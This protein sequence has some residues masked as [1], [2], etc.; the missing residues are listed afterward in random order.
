MLLI[1]ERDQFL[2]LFK[3]GEIKI[4]LSRFIDGFDVENNKSAITAET[5][6]SRM[7]LFEQ[8]HELLILEI[9]KEILTI[10]PEI[11]LKLS[12][13][14]KIYPLTDEADRYLFGKLNQKIVLQKPV[15]ENQ[16]QE[17]KIRRDF[18]LRIKAADSLA[19]LFK[20][21]K[22]LAGAYYDEIEDGI[23]TRLGQK[24]MA[25]HKK[26]IYNL[27]CFNRNPI[28]PQG[29]A[30]YTLKAGSVFVQM[31]GGSESDYEHG[32]FYEFHLSNAQLYAG[33]SME[34]SLRN[35][36]KRP[37]SKTLLEELHKQYSKIDV[38]SI[39]AWFLYF[40]DKLNKSSYDLAI[41]KEEV[42]RLNVSQPVETAVIIQIIGMLFNF[43]N[44]YESFYTLS[45]IPIFNK[46]LDPGISEQN[47]ILKKSLQVEKERYDQLNFILGQKEKRIEELEAKLADKL[48]TVQDSLKKLKPGVTD[49]ITAIV[50]EKEEP[51]SLI[52]EFGTASDTLVKDSTANS[53]EVEDVPNLTSLSSDQLA[54]TEQNLK[55]VSNDELDR[56][57]I[58]ELPPDV[59]ENHQ[60]FLNPVSKIEKDIIAIGELPFYIDKVKKTKKTKTDS[61]Q[62]N[63]ENGTHIKDKDNIETKEAWNKDTTS[64]KAPQKH[65]SPISIKGVI[66]N[67]LNQS[68]AIQKKESGIYDLMD[69][70][71]IV[72][73]ITERAIIK[74]LDAEK[75]VIEAILAYSAN[76]THQDALLTEIEE[77]QE[78]F[79]FSND[80]ADELKSIIKKIKE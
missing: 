73:I 65:Y 46:N 56:Y 40:K 31:K 26:Y 58:K 72:R 34:D 12:Q 37:E 54:S 68:V 20:V 76:I 4:P 36:Y 69:L 25:M 41:I 80:I 14:S 67:M 49:P 32:P 9:S 43:E 51:V 5:L 63:K 27:I 44:L 77:L 52:K 57:S 74:D 29:N 78:Q 38:F 8:D 64:S 47:R 11:S 7:P 13:V 18:N 66:G 50:S 6:E 15:F 21:D 19:I 17:V 75:T 42:E 59:N 48:K 71:E 24:S 53:P 60:E 10:A 1:I 16:V 45:S 70:N 61:S 33:M 62:E 2:K 30:E 23:K 3:F 79:G 35:T 55:A 39:G 22:S 28:Y